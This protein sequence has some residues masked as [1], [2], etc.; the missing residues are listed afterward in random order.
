MH[1]AKV[2]MQQDMAMKHKGPGGGGIAKIHSHLHARVWVPDPFPEGNL[3]GVSHVLVRYG[4][5]VLFEQHEVDLVNMEGMGLERAVLDGPVF[6]R[7]HLGGN[8]RF[9][10]WLKDSLLLPID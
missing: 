5:P 9:L 3:D 4:M 6:D 7:S 2:L 10:I 8:H 1:H